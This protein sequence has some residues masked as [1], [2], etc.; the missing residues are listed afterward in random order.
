MRTSI[1]QHLERD[2]ARREVL[3]WLRGFSNHAYSLRDEDTSKNTPRELVTRFLSHAECAGFWLSLLATGSLAEPRFVGSWRWHDRVVKLP[4]IPDAPDR[5]D[6]RLLA[7]AAL[8][9][10]DLFRHRITPTH[11]SEAA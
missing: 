7:C 5:D 2:A 1:S 11:F 6:A 3:G 10:D 4:H 8:L 9:R